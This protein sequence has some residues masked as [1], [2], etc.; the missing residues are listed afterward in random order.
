[1]NSFS[2]WL[3]FAQSARDCGARLTRTCVVAKGESASSWTGGGLTAP[4]QI[5]TL[6]TPSPTFCGAIVQAKP[7]GFTLDK[8]LSD[9]NRGIYNCSTA[10]SVKVAP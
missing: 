7:S 8:K 6:H 2:A 4:F 10:N 9:P 3:L 5:D 1:V